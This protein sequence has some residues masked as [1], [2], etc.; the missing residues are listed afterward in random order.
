M[1]LSDKI[2]FR[3]HFSITTIKSDGTSEIYEEKNLI[4]DVAR[5]H[6]ANLIAGV[7]CAPINCLKLGNKGHVGDNVLEFKAVGSQG[8]DSTRVKMFSE[9][10]ST[11]VVYTIDFDPVEAIA[12]LDP[13]TGVITPYTPQAT[14]IGGL[15]TSTSSVLVTITG[16]S[17]TYTIEIPELG[18]NS[19]STS[20]IVPYT[21][22][23]LYVDDKIFSMKTF[24][25]RIKDSSVKI[26]VKW[27]IIF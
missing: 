5:E 1:V 17:V 26:V 25:A 7:T 19:T 2:D 18:G 6:M 3:G 14:S 20:P 27:S 11:A 16:R 12:S 24:P 22:A 10:D 15:T 23:A 9:S 21:E 13:I 8:F 4:M